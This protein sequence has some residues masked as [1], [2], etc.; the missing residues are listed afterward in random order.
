MEEKYMHLAVELAKK[1][2]GFVNPNPLVGAVIVK[3]GRIIGQGWHEK[4]GGLH[5]ERNALKNCTE[6]PKGADMYVTLEPC[7]HYGQT[8]PC[9]EAIIEAGIKR[10]IAGSDDPNPLVQGRGVK[11]LRSEGIEVIT[12]VLKNE[13]DMLNDV[14]F[15]YITTGTPFTVIKYAMTMDG[16]ISTFTGE[17]KWITSEASRQNV[18]KSRCR[19]SAIMVGIST[20][21]R[22]DPILT[23]RL[24]NGRNPLRI[25]CDSRFRI[26]L[27]SQIIQTANEVPTLI[28][29]CFGN[30]DK[31]DALKK[32]GCRTALLPQQ[33]GKPDL[34]SLMNYL[35]KEKIDSV[36]VEGGGSL[37]YSVLK[38]NI[39]DKI[40]VYVAP[41][42][43]GGKDAK[44]P[45][46][47]DGVPF[48]DM[49]F[50]F[51]KPRVT[52]IGDDI[53]LEYYKRK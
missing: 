52:P 33:N 38:E 40:E 21:F 34:K 29:G 23:C 15:H 30:A 32:A 17:S 18:H 50:M 20:V 49:A 7:S 35:A 6:S 28:A 19:Y 46:E 9:T 26:P 8:P 47:G 53:F 48:P 51:E 37:N 41:K 22:D 12:G 44:T 42:I 16:K 1:G 5:A 24:E 13:C 36:L 11:L 27:S 43:F 31:L 2:I 45:V 10:V 3:D 14:F 39:A 25:I 4:Y